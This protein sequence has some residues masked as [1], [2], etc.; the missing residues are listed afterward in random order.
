MKET[1]VGYINRGVAVTPTV[2]KRP[3]Y[4]DWQNQRLT[5]EDVPLY[6]TNGQNI[7]ALNGNLLAGGCAWTWTC[8]RR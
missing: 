5:P 7:G 2:G 6:W 3:V 4:D 8:L 1:V